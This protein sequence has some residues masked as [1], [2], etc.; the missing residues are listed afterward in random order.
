VIS[1]RFDA[2][3]VVERREWGTINH[4]QAFS[5][6]SSHRPNEY[7]F[8]INDPVLRSV[9]EETDESGVPPLGGS[10]ARPDNLYGSFVYG[11][12]SE[13]QTFY[14]QANI[15]LDFKLDDIL[16]GLSA[17]AYYTVDNYQFFQNGKTEVP[18]TYA[19]RWE[20]DSVQYYPL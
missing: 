14:G 13:F 16:K 18:V 20:G 2:G 3:G 8:V 10:F 12:F 1:A 7:P 17:T 9:S 4:S 15:G 11:G 6:L 19:Q 5:A